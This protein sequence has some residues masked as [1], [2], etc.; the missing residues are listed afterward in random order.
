MAPGSK[1][2]VEMVVA[3]IAESVWRGPAP[4]QKTLPPRRMYAGGWGS[5]PLALARGSIMARRFRSLFGYRFKFRS[6]PSSCSFHVRNC[7]RR[8]RCQ[9]RGDDGLG[10]VS[11]RNDQEVGVATGSLA[12]WRG[13]PSTSIRPGPRYMRASLGPMGTGE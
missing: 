3:F 9:Q 7:A 13:G 1:P 8:H 2:A 4:C 11:L 10:L 6:R 12:G 5:F